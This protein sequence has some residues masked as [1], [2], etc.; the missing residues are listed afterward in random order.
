MTQV[1]RNFPKLTLV[2]MEL[3]KVV[4]YNAMYH[5]P[6]TTQWDSATLEQLESTIMAEDRMT[7]TPKQVA[8]LASQ[9]LQV[10]AQ[11][12]D[13]VYIPGGWAA[14]RWVFMLEVLSEPEQG[15]AIRY[16]FQ[17][18]STHGGTLPSGL[19]D[20]S[21]EFILNA[22]IAVNDATQTVQQSA[23]VLNNLSTKRT[24]E[25]FP[26]LLRPTDVLCGLEMRQEGYDL[27]TVVDTRTML[28]Q[29]GAQASRI[30]NIPTEYVAKLATGYRAGL[31]HQAFIDSLLDGIQHT[32]LYL[33]EPHLMEN[34]FIWMLV[35][36]R[37]TALPCRF[38]LAD[39]ETLQPG[40]QASHVALLCSDTLP[41]RQSQEAQI[42]GHVWN[43]DTKKTWTAACLGQMVPALMTELGIEEIHFTVS[44]QGRAEQ[45]PLVT[46]IV[47]SMRSRLKRDL[48]H[49]KDVFTQRFTEEILLDLLHDH[50]GVYLFKIEANTLGES[51]FNLSYYGG[52]LEAFLVPSFCDSLLSPMVMPYREAYQAAIE[53]VG[54][55]LHYML[56]KP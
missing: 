37:E 49:V 28:P 34:P 27:D 8:K 21:V 36:N 7:V 25:S 46:V 19:P 42:K 53:D 13:E 31:P 43:R 3:G 18:Y 23:T 52:H 2:K 16:F 22:F 35:K 51:W 32:N 40:F 5:R 10:S 44:G 12:G 29:G 48:I 54:S 9:V 20:A 4:G 39:L 11:P 1:P 50:T 55:A 47:R 33:S 26:Y 14:E 15:P 41:V 56:V 38:T 6:F 24:S 17:G 30:L 45:P